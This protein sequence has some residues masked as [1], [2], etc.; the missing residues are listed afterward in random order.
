V[1]NSRQHFATLRPE[2]PNNFTGKPVDLE[3]WLEAV[4]IYFGTLRTNGR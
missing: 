2:I 1:V 3:H 4:H